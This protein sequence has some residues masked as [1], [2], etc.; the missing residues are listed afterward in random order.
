MVKLL[1]MDR[2]RHLVQRY[3]RGVWVLAAAVLLMQAVPL[4]MHL[5]HVDDPASVTAS[6]VMDVHVAD[7][8]SQHQ[9]QH[10]HHDDVHVIDLNAETFVKKSDD[11]LLI[12]WL[13]AC[14][15]AIFIVPLVRSTW[16]PVPSPDRQQ[17]FLFLTAPPLRAPPR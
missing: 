14:V 8:A 12:P 1:R 5:H 10:Q 13:F 6:H 16:T 2:L 3:R 17:R 7:T 15:L 11:N 4:H 9:H